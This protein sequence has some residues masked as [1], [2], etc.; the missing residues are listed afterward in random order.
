MRPRMDVAIGNCAGFCVERMIA[1]SR[2]RRKLRRYYYM[3]RGWSRSG[4]LFLRGF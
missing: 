1:S 3:V 2:S 4:L